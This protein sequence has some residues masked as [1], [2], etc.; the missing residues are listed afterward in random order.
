MAVATVVVMRGA[1]TLDALDA[2]TEMTGVTGVSVTNVVSAATDVS[3][4][5]LNPR[6]LARFT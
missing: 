6:V 1:K 4:A 3:V 2:M 5:A